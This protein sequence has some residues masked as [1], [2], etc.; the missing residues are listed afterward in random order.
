MPS[1]PHSSLKLEEKLNSSIPSHPLTQLRRPQPPQPHSHVNHSSHLNPEVSLHVHASRVEARCRRRS[2][3][4]SP[5]FESALSVFTV[6]P[7]LSS[8]S[9]CFPRRPTSLF[10]LSSSDSW[11]LPSPLTSLFILFILQV[12]SAELQR[13]SLS[14]TLTIPVPLPPCRLSLLVAASSSRLSLI[15]LLS[16]AASPCHTR[17]PLYH[18]ATRVFLSVIVSLASSGCAYTFPPAVSRFSVSLFSACNQAV[19]VI[20]A[21][22]PGLMQLQWLSFAD[23][24][25]LYLVPLLALVL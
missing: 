3:T 23:F 16:L 7:S 24:D 9:S 20:V 13:Y 22:D 25:H 18:R 19:W 15:F 8:T 1:S 21:A 6:P 11:N 4:L 5:L 17:L 14:L 12:A 2:L 10:I